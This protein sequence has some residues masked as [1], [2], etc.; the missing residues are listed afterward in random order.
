MRR[1]ANNKVS[2]FRQTSKPTNNSPKNK[3]GNPLN[4]NRLQS[5]RNI[6]NN[7]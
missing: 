3:N 4:N 6:A 5:G 2:P 7:F 1:M